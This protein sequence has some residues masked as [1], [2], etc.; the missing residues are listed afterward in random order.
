M[1]LLDKDTAN[2]MAMSQ[3][4][5]LGWCMKIAGIIF[6]IVLGLGAVLIAAS[7]Y[8]TIT[9]WALAILCALMAWKLGWQTYQ[10]FK[11]AKN[12]FKNA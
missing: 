3:L 4:G 2:A 7:A 10:K 11:N 8:D 12:P 5:M 6:L 1:A 9:G